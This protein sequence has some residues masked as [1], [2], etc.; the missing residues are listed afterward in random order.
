MSLDRRHLILTS[1]AAALLG[2]TAR[3]ATGPNPGSASKAEV[4]QSLAPTGRLRAAINYGNTVLAQRNPQTGELTGVS[5]VLANTLGQRLGVAVDLV[6]F[7]AAG[8]VFDALER[9]AWDIAFL[10]IEPERA[11][12]IEFSPPYVMIDGTYMVRRNSAFRSVADLD[13]PGLK[14]AVATGAAYDLYLSRNLKNAALVRS[15]TSPA[16]VEMFMASEEIAGV[17]G[18]RQFLIDI[19]RGKPGYRV[20]ED[21]FS[22]IDQAMAIPR[23]RPAAGAAYI[24]DFLEEMKASGVIRKALDQTAQDAATVAPPA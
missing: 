13:K 2:A 1:S 9:Q 23:G 17:A 20:I 8:M 3:A 11:V 18:V 22:R 21:R 4:V 14:I 5:V 15:P 24:H 10:A 6:P 7:A 19:G 12:K 16:A